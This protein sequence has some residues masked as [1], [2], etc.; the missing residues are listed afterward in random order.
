M[1]NKNAVYFSSL[2][3]FISAPILA[4]DAYISASK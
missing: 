2:V 4:F 1:D 3:Y